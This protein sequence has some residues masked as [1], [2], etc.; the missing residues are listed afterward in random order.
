MTGV[1]MLLEQNLPHIT[2]F[3]R[4]IILMMYDDFVQVLELDPVI[5][6]SG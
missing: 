1:K 5:Y 3:L 4:A 6:I 2:V